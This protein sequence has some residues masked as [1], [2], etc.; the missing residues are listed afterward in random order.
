MLG[1]LSLKIQRPGIDS[2]SRLSPESVSLPRKSG[3]MYF[4][5]RAFRASAYGGAAPLFASPVYLL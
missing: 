5:V 4:S 2:F 3:Q 1:S